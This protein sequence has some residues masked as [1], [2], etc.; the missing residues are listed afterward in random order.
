V[1][2]GL[3]AALVLPWLD[4]LPAAAMSLALAYGSFVLATP[5]S[6]SPG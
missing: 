5:C 2:L 6:G 1:L 3:V 4:P